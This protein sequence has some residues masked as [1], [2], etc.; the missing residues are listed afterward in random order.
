MGRG[1]YPTRNVPI[2]MREVHVNIRDATADD[3][4]E[5]GASTQPGAPL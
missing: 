3:I 1:P 2:R 5:P 4:P